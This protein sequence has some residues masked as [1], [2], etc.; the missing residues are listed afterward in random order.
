MK[1]GDALIYDYSSSVSKEEIITIGSLKHN[2][3]DHE[4]NNDGDI[5][6]ITIVQ[7]NIERGYQLDKVIKLIRECNADVICI[8]EI[9]IDCV[10]SHKRNCAQELAKQL[11]MKCICVIEF[12][13]LD[14][15]GVHGNAILSRLDFELVDVILHSEVFNWNELGKSKGEARIGQRCT[16]VCKFTIRHRSVLIYS[17]HLEVFTGILGRVTQI[18]EI[19]N[20]AN[21]ADASLQI[22]C[23]DLNTLGHGIARLSPSYCNDTMRWRSIGYSES[24]FFYDRVLKF[25]TEDGE[26]NESLKG[27][28][29]TDEILKACRNPGFHEVFDLNEITLT[30]YGGAFQGKLDW[31][32]VKGFKV[33][34]K[35]MKNVDFNASDHKLLCCTLI[36]G[37][38]D[39]PHNLTIDR[40]TKLFTYGLIFATT[41]VAIT[42]LYLRIKKH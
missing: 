2:L 17:A 31:V 13:E 41:T 19:F 37:E 34:S 28:G 26:F 23:G 33:K 11:K 27:Y 38:P 7:F 42:S 30:S 29:L 15:Q 20:F 21:R 1:F 16:M 14:E 3:K 32:L 36:N 5:G 39:D 35:Y 12:E 22:L 4:M 24:E 10:R 8:Q 6:P 25:Y 40:R 9:D 18:S